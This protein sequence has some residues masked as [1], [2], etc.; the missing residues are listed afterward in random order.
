MHKMCA[1]KCITYNKRPTDLQGRVIKK[2]N[3]LKI[4]MAKIA[5][6]YKHL[7]LYEVHEMPLEKDCRATRQ[8]S[9]D[10]NTVE[11]GNTLCVRYTQKVF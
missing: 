2:T 8:W 9:A 11:R 7:F 6:F 5:G 1:K 10:G 4:K 3:F